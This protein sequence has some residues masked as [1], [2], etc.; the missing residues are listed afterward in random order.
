MAISAQTYSLQ[1]TFTDQAETWFSPPCGLSDR[2]GD[3]PGGVVKP[4]LPAEPGTG[5][6]GG[7]GGGGGDGTTTNSNSG[8]DPIFIIDPTIWNGDPTVPCI[9][10]CPFVLPPITLPTPTVFEFPPLVKPLEVGWWDPT[11]IVDGST[12]LSTY[13]YVTVTVTM[14]I[15]VSPVT[16]SVVSVSN[17]VVSTTGQVIISPEPSIVAPVF[18]ITD[19]NPDRVS[20]PPNTRPFTPSPIK[21]DTQTT[22]STTSCST[23]MSTSCFSEC[24]RGTPSQAS[25]STCLGESLSCCSPTSQPRIL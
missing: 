14:T 10:P 17:V 24:I 6:G 7:G 15:Q 19:S 3:D 2:L 9:P 20:H 8:T 11:V 25:W 13:A 1:G 5:N 4:N 18:N 23:S 22:P 21:P 12:T 16:A